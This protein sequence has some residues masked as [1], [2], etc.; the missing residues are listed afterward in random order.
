MRPMRTRVRERWPPAMK[1]GNQS[2]FRS[3]V[4]I[5]RFGAPWACG[6]SGRFSFERLSTS[7]EHQVLCDVNHW[8]YHPENPSPKGMR[9]FTPF[10]LYTHAAAVDFVRQN[11]GIMTLYFDDFVLY[12]GKP[13]LLARSAK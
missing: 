13:A 2:P 5:A 11:G 6:G 7:G 12:E 3:G 8:T 10:I 1:L 9:Y 4:I